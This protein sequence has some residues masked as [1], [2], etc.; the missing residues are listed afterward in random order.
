MKRAV[1][2]THPRGG[3][4]HHV[5]LQKKCGMHANGVFVKAFSAINVQ[6]IQRRTEY[7]PVVPMGWV[8]G[9][10][11][12]TTGPGH[13]PTG[14]VLTVSGV[15][16][17]RCQTSPPGSP[18]P[19]ST[20]RLGFGNGQRPIRRTASK[21]FPSSPRT[22]A[23]PNTPPP[24]ASATMPPAAAPANP[25]PLPPVPTFTPCPVGVAVM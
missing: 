18:R 16:T 20:G 1:K 6:H 3:P 7:S 12:R 14:G 24:P 11:P 19:P 21:A 15:R 5:A 25:P 13:R 22:Y 9:A 8:P 2:P 17:P 4:Q 10:K 23:R